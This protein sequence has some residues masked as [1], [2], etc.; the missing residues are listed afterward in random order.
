[1]EQNRLEPRRALKEKLLRLLRDGV[2]G[3][4]VLASATLSL[5]GTASAVPSADARPSLAERVANLRSQAAAQLES[6]RAADDGQ[7]RLAWGNWHSWRNG[8]P[9]RN[10]HNWGNW[11]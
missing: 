2:A 11:G 6:P 10:W 3:S 4:V 9:W 8:G 7:T 1:M 5:A